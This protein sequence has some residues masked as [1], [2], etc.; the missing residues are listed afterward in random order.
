MIE[1]H[2]PAPAPDIQV[3]LQTLH[4]SL[5]H[6]TTP[7]FCLF[8]LHCTELISGLVS[9]IEVR[10]TGH[11]QGNG[12]SSCGPWI[13]SPNAVWVLINCVIFSPSWL[14]YRILH[15][16]HNVPDRQQYLLVWETLKIGI[17][18]LTSS[19]PFYCNDSKADGIWVWLST[20]FGFVLWL[21]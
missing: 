14:W 10:S 16:L 4:I 13:H 9:D 5:E 15:Y 3:H 2:C 8:Y 19:F 11:E 7:Y 6:N 12:W 18:G 17:V 1:K 21:V 20:C